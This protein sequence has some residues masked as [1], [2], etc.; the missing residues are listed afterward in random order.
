MR[1]TAIEDAEYKRYTSL[2]D[3]SEYLSGKTVLITGS[4]GIVGSGI[5]RWLLYENHRKKNGTHIIASSREPDIIPQ[6]IDEGDDISF[7]R[8]GNECDLTEQ[9]DYIIHT[10]AP[11]SNIVFKENPVE[12]LCS[13]IDGAETILKL[14]KRETGCS[15]IYLSSE[16]VY[17]TP[18]EKLP[19]PETFVG[20][21]D[22]LS[23]RNCYPLG[24]K[25]CELLCK[26]YYEE[27]GVDVK[28]IRP[29]VI[30]GLFQPYSSVKVEAEILRCIV[31]NKN[32]YMKSNGMTKKSVIY[33]MDAISAILTVL[34]K[35]AAGEAYNATNP[36][37]FA[38][39]RDRAYKAFSL[40]NPS[41][42]VEFAKQDNAVDFGYLPQRSLQEN[43]SKLINLGW[44]PLT[45]MDEIYEIEISRFK[46]AISDGIN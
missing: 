3:F 24:K 16:E 23:I 41:I 46:S 30:L 44:S 27:Y 22:S 11:T 17:G 33:T 29:T 10:A 9:I 35:G 14:A 18:N 20:T 6:Y 34:F 36:D 39:V 7:C 15:V 38:T 8:F 5:I 40:F 28:I 25:T 45:S 31:E 26:A 19:V 42:S 32:L 13:I 21:I 43:I 12:S 37:T 4:K 1:L 2:Y